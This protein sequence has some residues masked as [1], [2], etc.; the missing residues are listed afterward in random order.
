[1]YEYNNGLEPAGRTPRLYLAKGGEV[2]KFMGQNIPDFCAVAAS[3]YQKNGKWSN[4]TYQLDLAPGVRPL[5]FLSPMHGTW[6]DGIVSWGKL[7]E[8]LG[9]PVDVAQSLIRAEY[10]RTA[11]RLDKLEE[12]AMAVEAKGGDT[13]T[14]VISFGS[15]TNREISGGYWDAPK[16][17]WTSDERIVT[18]E[19]SKGEFGSD[20]SKPQIV[21]PK[22][23]ILLSSRHHPGMHGG[24]YTIEVAVPIS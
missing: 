13:E 20:W 16:S 5:Y 15:P 22:G 2:R 10:K 19:P 4:T 6:G 18:V 24:C 7:A 9:L 8:S 21:A 3:R 12:F 23:A 14:V 17:G 1:M 11:E